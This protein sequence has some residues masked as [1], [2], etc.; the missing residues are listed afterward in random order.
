MARSG[1]LSTDPRAESP[2]HIPGK[3][4]LRVASRPSRPELVVR[5]ET[6]VSNCTKSMLFASRPRPPRLSVRSPC[7]DAR[8]RLSPWWLWVAAML[9]VGCP[10]GK[11][12]TKTTGAA[13]RQA[14][15]KS[16]SP[17]PNQPALDAGVAAQDAEVDAGPDA[18]P[19]P[20][21]GPWFVVTSSAAGIYQEP[22]F[23]RDKK[24]GWARNGA[25]IPVFAEPV[26]KLKCSGNWYRI[27]DGGHICGNQGTI[28]PDDPSLKFVMNQPDL[29]GVLPYKYVRN[30]KNGTPLYKSV[31]SRDQMLTYEPY[32]AKDTDESGKK[33]ST[34]NTKNR[35]GGKVGRDT[36]EARRAD[37][38]TPSRSPSD[39]SDAGARALRRRLDQALADA[40]IELPIDTESA[41]AAAPETPWWQREGIKD[42]LHK[43]KLEDLHEDAD[44]ILAKRMVT[45]FY[46]AVDKTFR[47]N[48]RS[49]YKT[50]RGLVTPTE[51]FW[52]AAASEFHGVELGEKWQLP[53]AWVYGW[54][55]SSTLYELD[56]SGKSLKPVGEAK[57]F[58]PMQ[59][60]G[61]TFERN[62]RRYYETRE[63]RWVR[64]S[65]IRIADPGPPPEGLAPTER[66]LD[67]NLHEQTL[68][69]FDGHRAVYAT[70]ISSGKESRVKDKD[71]RTPVGEWKI[72]EKH[73]TTT[74]DGDGTAAGDLP[75]SIED[76]PYVMYFHQAYA[77]HGAFWHRNFGVQMSHGCVNL[78]PLDA[79]W[80]FF[81]TSP[82]LPRGWHGVWSRD[83]APG[84][85]VVIHE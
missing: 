10:E 33:T 30:A 39:M 15:P 43:L 26:S 22:S 5:T 14:S 31:P 45:G 19:A 81:F 64:E 47:W 4:V 57:H 73:L 48:G 52:G 7:H 28:D 53:V 8:L 61:K 12:T 54:R 21:D 38:S 17:R 11:N 75:Y 82:L 68:V 70:L 78:A 83:G 74:M 84:S 34:K 55:K 71:H 59:L 20:H 16:P 49:W 3:D 37:A 80:V 50:T 76:V 13:P 36:S 72:R 41:D 42:E 62:G 40:G 60:T 18:G 51:R 66:W 6:T 32:L 79:K 44:D 85:R 25:R 46:V 9:A 63:Q 1:D 65:H 58:E 69:A 24:I 67:I 77:V 35:D 23:D 56:A 29:D 2:W 27:V